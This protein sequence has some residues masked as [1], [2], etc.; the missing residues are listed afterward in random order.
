MVKQL[1]FLLLSFV[2]IGLLATQVFFSFEARNLRPELGYVPTP[3]KASF[4]NVLSLGDKEFVF[5]AVALM[6]QNSG[7]TFGRFSAL[8]LYDFKKLKAWFTL[9]DGLNSKSDI[10]PFMAA[11]YFSQ[12]QN[13][14]DV[15]Y[16]VDFIYNHSIKDVQKKW[17][18]LMQGMY[19]TNHKLNSPELTLKL[20]LPLKDPKLPVMAQELLAIVYEGRGEFEQAYDIIMDIQKN[21]DEID[22][23]ELRY[24]QYFV[25]ERLN[26]M[27]SYKKEMEA[28]GKQLL[29]PVK[30]EKPPKS[31]GQH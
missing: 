24:M 3:P 27:D 15:I 10:M 11:Y 29:P 8:K 13:T 16:M 1:R 14:K 25:E 18:W 6:I 7:D 2:A 26:R 4:L 17:W 5:R 23:K 28:I 9:Q 31:E 22:E 21:V 20:A 30:P 12:T 19:L